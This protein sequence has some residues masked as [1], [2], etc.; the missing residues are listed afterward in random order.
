MKNQN[1]MAKSIILILTLM[2]SALVPI[3]FA[4]PLPT[5]P[6]NEEYMSVEG[7]LDSDTYILYPYEEESINIGFSKY[8]EM[9]NGD[10]GLGLEYKGVDVFANGAVPEELWC[11][12]W[13]MDIHFTEAGYLRN[14]WAHALY[15]DYSDQNGIG[16]PWQNFQESKDASAVGDTHGGR[17]TNGYAESDD[18][19]VLY[20]GPRKAIYLLNT[21]IYDKD[22]Q[23]KGTPLVSI[24]IQLVFDKVSK[25]VMEIKDIKR[26][27]DNKMNGPFQ[28]EFSQR[29][30][31]DIGL[32][33]ASESYAEFYDGIPTKYNKHP[34]YTLGEEHTP[35]KQVDVSL[36]QI[37]GEEDLVGYAA[38]WPPLISKWVT[39]VGS[40][41]R[42]DTRVD[43]P[44]LL[45]TMETF[46]RYV[47]LPEDAFDF[48][49]PGTEQMGDE[50]AIRLFHDPVEY[51]RGM[52][53][54]SE[55]PWV[56]RKDGTG[57][58]ARL[59]QEVSPAPGQWRW[60]PG[61]GDHG[62]VFI[63]DGQWT[64]DDEFVIVYK[65]VMQ[66]HTPHQDVSALDCMPWEGF[67]AET[68]HNSLGM[69]EEPDTPFVL[70]EWDFDLDMD[71]PENSTH[72]FRC[73]SVYGVTDNHNAVD[74]DQ[75]GQAGTFR[76]DE[77]VV[78]QLNEIFNPWDLTD[79][80][81]LD[82][83][84]WAQK[85]TISGS[86]IDLSSHETGDVNHEVWVPPK[87][88]Y[89]CEDSEK[90][91][92]YTGSGAVLL[93]RP[94][95]YDFLDPDTIELSTE[96]ASMYSGDLYKV[97]YSTKRV[98][99]MEIDE[100]QLSADDFEVDVIKEDTLDSVIWK[101]QMA[102]VDSS[103]STGVQ[104]IIGDDT[105][106]WF[107]IGWSPGESTTDPIFKP[108]DGGWGAATTDLPPGL[109][110]SGGYN[111]YYYEITIPRD[112]LGL[113]YYWAINVEATSNADLGDSSS[114]QQNYPS[115]WVR[116]TAENMAKTCFKGPHVGQYEWT[117]LG[118]ASLPSDSLGA[119]MLSSAWSDWKNIEVWL[120]AL[121]VDASLAPSI[122][123]TL[124]KFTDTETPSRLNYHYDHAGGD[125]RAAFRDDWCTPDDWS[126]ELIHPKAISSSDLII[127]GGPLANEAAMYFNDFTDALIFT[128]YGD[129]FYGPGCWA[130]TVNPHYQGMDFVDVPKHE[131]WY[132]S[133]TTE[134]DIGHAIVST[135]KDLNETVGFIV[136]GYT[137]EDTYYTC[138]ALRG[139]LLPWMQ[140]LQE[141]VTTLII[142]IDYSDLHPVKFHVKES[143][144]RFTECTGFDTD[145][146]CH[147][148]YENL[149]MNEARV[150]NEATA[151]G[152]PYKYVEV[153]WCAQLHPDP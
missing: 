125:H 29:A 104:V 96:A 47:E 71:H 48:W 63:K 121:E 25:N 52:G 8:G 28:I 34:F 10:A 146:K 114:H 122:P 42:Y 64:W 17:R 102:G 62:T 77:E 147:K 101:V 57:G 74:P 149:N 43:V 116:W 82:S 127:V 72:H 115:D 38:F 107:N 109:M 51:P 5:D 139:G 138:S 12:G 81:H 108:Y 83:F 31:W 124:R 30:E 84:R 75:P 140:R 60:E 15:T 66:G 152:I 100:S 22:E 45:S 142:E 1:T 11:S 117:V 54:W 49:Q 134:D 130:R 79:S 70:A 39:D 113:C 143:L 53:V 151:L 68:M 78:Y 119:S 105:N 3:A 23:Q 46:E 73:V 141:G 40:I 69:Y 145:F 99:I 67:E 92:V 133:T 88:G 118:E 89:Y 135:Y 4:G 21:T 86:T 80:V 2:L 85:G 148:Y 33:Q 123:V 87:W 137:A 150:M 132:D 76:I 50:V 97:L 98:D 136:Y 27:D 16:G 61:T 55:A 106:P 103:T 19:K 144:G 95:D 18:I 65:R 120:S 90:V 7:L 26:I 110:V 41:T 129:G 58:Y 126:G 94:E 111:E 6:G 112:Y 59:F 36:C 131:L 56:F 153:E 44:N 32:T 20:D 13:V 35:D 14:I 24:T 9:I 37:I 93:E 91:M 128:N